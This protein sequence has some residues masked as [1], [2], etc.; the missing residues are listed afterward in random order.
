MNPLPASAGRAGLSDPVLADLIDEISRKLGAGEPVDLDAYL[1]DCPEQAEPLR[2]LLPA[3][4]MMARLGA[5]GSSAAAPPAHDPSVPRPGPL[6]DFLIRREVGRGGMGVVYE[7]EQLSLGRRVALKVLPFAAALDA[8]QLAR[9]K[10]EAQAAAQLHHGNIVPVYG[11]GADRG[12]HY[13][14]MQFI[15]GQ[16]LAELIAALRRQRG[17]GSGVGG[18]ATGPYALA[19]GGPDPARTAPLA[20]LSTERPTADEAFFRWAA[21][22]GVQAAEALEHAHQFGIV[23][24]DVKPGNLL[25]DGRDR[26]WVT[27]F[28]LAHCQA[29]AGLTLTGD[30]VGT[31]RYMSPEQALARRVVID[32]R[33]DVYS[34]GATLYELLTLRPAFAGEDRQ[35]LLRQI[36]FEEPTAPRRL[37]GAV[38]AELE[39]VVLKA[40][41]KSPDERYATAQELAD[42]LGRY[43][44]DEPIW[45]RRPT[46][47]QRARKWARRHP[48]AVWSVAACLLVA[49]LALAG[50]IGWG[51]RDRAVRQSALEQKVS[52]ALDDTG[53]FCKR[54]KLPEALAALKRAEGLLASGRGGEELWRR[55]RQWESNL[56][57]VDRLDAIRLHWG[58]KLD[59][60][61]AVTAYAKAFREYGLP[62]DSLDPAAAAGRV[63]ASGIKDHLVVALDNWAWRSGQP[64]D[65]ALRKHLLAITR[66]ADPDDWR[67]RM[68]ELAMEKDRQ[69]LRL[70]LVRLASHP[71]IERQPPLML[72]QLASALALQDAVPEAAAVLQRA[73]RRYPADFWINALLA[74]QLTQLTPPQR[75]RAIGYYRAALALRP[76]SAALRVNLGHVLLRHG[77]LDEAAACYDE[78][79]RL[80]PDQP[81]VHVGLGLLARA[82][83]RL[84]EALTRFREAIRLSPSYA[85]AHY[86]LGDTLKDQ[87]QLADALAAYEEAIRVTPDKALEAACRNKVGM[88]LKKQGKYPEAIAAY[89]K[90]IECDPGLAVAHYNLGNSLRDAGE[91]DKAIGSFQK[92]IALD[93][94]LAQAHCNLGRVLEQKGDRAGAI[95][96]YQRAVAADPKLALPHFRLG[97]ALGKKGDREGA[98]EAYRRAVAAEPKHAQAHYNLGNALLARGDREGARD[99]YQKAVAAEPKLAQAHNNLGCVLA[100]K[101]DWRGAVKAFQEALRLKPDLAQAQK[102]LNDVARVLALSPEPEAR[103]PKT[104]LALARQVVKLSPK[105]A[106]YWSTLGAAHYRVGEWKAAALALE[107]AMELRKGGGSFDWFF[108]GMAR[109]Q[110]GEKDEARRWYDRAAAW[111]DK[112]APRD[113][114]LRRFQA[115]AAALLKVADGA[116]KKSGVK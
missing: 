62:V 15:D 31:L 35:D 116:K 48:S 103:D 113:E 47:V 10:N 98:M 114:E 63:V 14:A 93:P 30:L 4:H 41:A 59:A 58:D 83:G 85:N 75:E 28:G 72:Y 43:L 32:Q 21:R 3:L 29:Q 78:A 52:Q 88:I 87:G 55:V 13:Y 20:A 36:A 91:R 39:T 1:R 33:T 89:Q 110:L 16:S 6:G 96:A 60:P 65:V 54:D 66:V 82:Q 9:F 26:L 106:D 24:R 90:A 115:E 69:A 92:A 18:E 112:H 8:R 38:P 102:S 73:Q 101:K 107:R 53:G 50:S 42:D 56:A 77:Q 94:N 109:W 45:A 108:L 49:V 2:H 19:A 104:A 86:Y 25:L 27:D 12:V 37:N 95:L 17:P 76:Q 40:M 61:E 111:A 80:W 71:E 84:P 34:L 22:L 23:H 79:L 81:R 74:W 44:R 11:V 68:R 99:A 51:V 97:V 5:G 105:N 64:G 57:M 70:A 100:E 46:L 7:A 67:N